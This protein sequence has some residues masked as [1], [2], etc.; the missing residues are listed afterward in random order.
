M[1]RYSL[2]LALAV[3]TLRGALAQ[4]PE[5]VD[6]STQK[7]APASSGKYALSY[8]R[9][10]PACRTYALFE[11]DQTIQNMKSAV[12]DP[13][14]FRLFENTFPN[15]LDTTI[16]WK[17]FARDNANEEVRR[18]VPLVADACHAPN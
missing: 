16:S 3:G 9:P 13:D 11:V 5:Y 15:T 12:T 6:Y 7:H 8:M 17:G 4:C 18:S 1:F 14:L 10:T 2:S